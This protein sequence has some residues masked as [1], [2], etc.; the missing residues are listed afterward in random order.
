[1]NTSHTKVLG[2]LGHPVAHSRSPALFSSWIG[3]AGRTDLVYEAFDV[4]DI[5][6]FA[7]WQSMHPDVVGL[8]VTV[9]HKQAIL[10]YL[11]DLSM[12]AEAVGAVNTIVRT[13]HGWVGHNTD[14]WGFQ[15][16]IQ[17]FLSKHHERALV[18][19]TG[20]SAAA[21][22]HVLASL[23]I[24]A[25]GVSR[26]GDSKQHQQF[27][28]RPVIGYHELGPDLLRHHL[29]IVNCTPCGMAPNVHDIAPVPTEELTEQHLVVDLIYAPEETTLLRLA[30]AKGAATLNGL[31]MLR[32]QAEKSWEIWQEAGV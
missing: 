16:S 2:V 31:D 30:K 10:P 7:N 28:G 1:M 18:L 29:L 26:N 25:V 23:G 22:H 11:R 21:V 32:L 8:N 3:Q 5:S 13:Q 15:R 27:R 14:V 12:E 20:G 6:D 17:P 24:D 9:P 19:G 4:V